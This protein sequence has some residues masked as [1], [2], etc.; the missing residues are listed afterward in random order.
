M[1][2]KN[3]FNLF[4]KPIYLPLLLAGMALS[5][6]TPEKAKALRLGAVQFQAE[7]IACIDAIN[8]MHQKELEAPPRTSKEIEEEFIKN[9][10][11][12][13]STILDSE[14]IALAL[15]PYSVNI[16]TGEKWQEF[17]DKLSVQYASF[18]NIYNDLEQGS[19]LAAE[20]V[21]KSAKH[22]GNLT[23]QMAGFT[24]II[25]DNPPILLQY[26]SDIAANLTILKNR[27]QSG[28]SADEKQEIRS[29]TIDLLTQWQQVK[30]Q[31]EELKDGTVKQCLQA[32]VMGKELGE[33]IEDYDRLD[34]DI[35]NTIISGIFD[36]VGSIASKDFSALKLQSSNLI[37]QIKEDEILGASAET[38]LREV[39]IAVK[40]RNE[41]SVSQDNLEPDIG[42]A[43]QWLDLRD[44]NQIIGEL[45]T[46][47][48]A[49]D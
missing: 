39:E 43:T 36:T 23:I 5:G 17:I 33:L 28:V 1:T 15:D 29:A 7:S 49:T 34:L 47:I 16:S 11:S 44:D 40:S 37:A 9:I 12:S 20:S 24:Q 25:S 26:R 38:I 31:E 10:L 32:S 48:A 4:Y 3:L 27:Y 45:N 30:V 19:F 8:T 41:P 22:A 2:K 35:I 46:L 18:S 13:D 21:E 42:Q 14:E 6:C